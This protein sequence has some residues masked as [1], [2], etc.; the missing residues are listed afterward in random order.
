MV[1]G[2]LLMGM[3]VQVAESKKLEGK[4]EYKKV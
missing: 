1:L 4:M 2:W 3:D